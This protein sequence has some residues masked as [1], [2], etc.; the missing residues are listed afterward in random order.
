VAS[1]A[2]SLVN[3][4]HVTPTRSIPEFSLDGHRSFADAPATFFPRDTILNGDRYV[5]LSAGANDGRSRPGGLGAVCCDGWA[6]AYMKHGC[7][8]TNDDRTRLSSDPADPHSGRYALKIHIPTTVPVWLPIPVL[9]KHAP[10]P[11]TNDTT[12][13]LT[14]WVRSSPVSVGVHFMYGALANS[15]DCSAVELL[16]TATRGWTKLR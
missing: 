15:T 12:Y 16:G 4:C 8:S 1:S 9:T 14:L 5:S 10:G 7:C 3:L 2:F 6:P 13:N 11:L